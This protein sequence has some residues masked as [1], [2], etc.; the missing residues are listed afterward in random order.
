M[1]YNLES[2]LSE[3]S[4]VIVVEEGKGSYKGESRNH[5]FNPNGRCGAKVTAYKDGK[6]VY[7]SMNASTLPDSVSIWYSDNLNGGTPI[8]TVCEGIYE[9]YGKMHL[10]K[11][12]AL[13]LGLGS[14]TVPVIRRDK[15]STSSAIN[16]HYRALDDPSAS[17]IWASSTGCITMLKNE[18]YEMF[19]V[20]GI[21]KF[22]GNHVG[23]IIID[24]GGICEDKKL[25][26]DYRRYFKNTINNFATF[27][28]KPV[29]VVKPINDLS[30]WAKDG[31]E[32]VTD[33]NISDGLRPKDLV[34]RE[35]MWTML[36][37]FKK[38]FDINKG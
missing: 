18:L 30:E 7:T 19:E 21:N 22:N 9:V 31:Y 4:I 27:N 12:K 23:K 14:Q 6:I 16:F 37:R 34:T 13:E 15:V 2:L 36:E 26:D 28:L 17:S 20:L 32:F 3:N 10:G 5:G 25:Y 38:M 11:H 8:P 24:R 35:E 33:N 29:K 1:N